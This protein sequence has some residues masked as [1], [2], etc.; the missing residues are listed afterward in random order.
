VL[1]ISDT[2]AITENSVKLFMGHYTSAR[3]IASLA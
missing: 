2:I 1:G 3:G